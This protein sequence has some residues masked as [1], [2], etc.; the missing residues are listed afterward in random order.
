[1]RVYILVYRLPSWLN[2]KE[3]TCQCKRCR[4][5]CW[6]R[7]IP[8]RRKLQP[9]PVFLLGKS[10]G[11]RCLEGYS[12]WGWK[13]LPHDWATEQRQ[14][15]QQEGREGG[16]VK[17]SWALQQQRALQS[18]EKKA[19]R[20]SPPRFTSLHSDHSNFLNPSSPLPSL[21]KRWKSSSGNLCILLP[22]HVTYRSYLLIV[23]QNG[24]SLR[25]LSWEGCREMTSGKA[26]PSA[27]DKNWQAS[28]C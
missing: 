20:I 25:A 22:S 3:S 24:L 14:Q 6:V 2:S 19:L 17:T 15:Q 13:R 23:K 12:P 10:H 27:K 7:K 8:W 9:T 1:M 11:Y 21:K 16:P 18:M 4:F 5:N 28:L 26:Q